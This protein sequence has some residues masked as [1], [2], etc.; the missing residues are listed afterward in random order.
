MG[1]IGER[2]A[3]DEHKADAGERTLS[4]HRHN[5]AALQHKK[6]TNKSKKQKNDDESRTA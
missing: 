4:M 6:V 3:N 5:V 1:S 2:R